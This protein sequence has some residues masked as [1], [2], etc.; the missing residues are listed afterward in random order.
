[1]SP[2][3]LEINK[4]QVNATVLEKFP[5]LPTGR[6][7]FQVNNWDISPSFPLSVMQVRGEKSFR[8]NN[9]PSSLVFRA[10]R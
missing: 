10:A 9:K 3:W 1:M 7:P 6:T 5:S 8:W 4:E 2:R